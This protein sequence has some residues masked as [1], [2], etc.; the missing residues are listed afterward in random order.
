MGHTKTSHYLLGDC[1][2]FR[3]FRKGHSTIWGRP[4]VWKNHQKRSGSD[5]GWVGWGIRCSPV[6]ANSGSQIKGE[7]IFGAHLCLLTG[8]KK[9]SIREKIVSVTTHIH[10]KSCPNP[11]FSSFCTEASHF[12]CFLYVPHAF[13][14]SSPELEF[15]LSI[16]L[17]NWIYSQSF[18]DL[19]HVH[20]QKPS[21]PLSQNPCWFS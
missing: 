16:F 11:C 8:Y 10:K 21:I 9:G 5:A 4:L 12:I 6:Q 1:E 19:Q 15:I 2:L 18:K 17:S 7:L 14:A 20:L 13:Q 3:D